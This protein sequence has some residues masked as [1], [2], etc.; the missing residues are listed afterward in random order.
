[1]QVVHIKMVEKN[2]SEK[3]NMGWVI[4]SGGCHVTQL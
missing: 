2:K 4:K 3:D 1:M